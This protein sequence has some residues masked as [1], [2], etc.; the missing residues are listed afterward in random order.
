MTSSSTS[1]MVR[2]AAPS[3]IAACGI[4]K[5]HADDAGR[6]FMEQER[7]PGEIGEMP[8]HVA[9]RA[10]A[11][12]PRRPTSR[13]IAA[14]RSP[15]R[16]STMRDADMRAGF[17]RAGEREE[18][19]CGEQ[20]AADFVE[21]EDDEIG[22][23]KMRRVRARRRGCGRRA[24]TDQSA[25]PTRHKRRGPERRG[26]KRVERAAHDLT[27][28]RTLS[29]GDAGRQ[30]AHISSSCTRRA[31]PVPS[32]PAYFSHSVAICSPILVRPALSSATA[33]AP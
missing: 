20:V 11:A 12:R 30:I 4:A 2:M 9:G 10:A 31:S 16:S 24:A 8:G 33:A 23:R 22:A 6:D 14:R 27:R 29:G 7:D 3:A 15:T 28:R 25:M 1:A 21:R 17:Q 19:R 13:A 5:R 18:A 32:A 26:V